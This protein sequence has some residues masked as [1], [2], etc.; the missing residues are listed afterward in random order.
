VSGRPAVFLDRD[1]T[2]IEDRHKLHDPAA[3]ELVL[4]AAV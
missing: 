3:V 4:G 2:L 1:G